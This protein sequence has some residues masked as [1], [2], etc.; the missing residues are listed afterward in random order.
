MKK[1]ILLLVSICCLAGNG[2]AEK[3][4]PSEMP[5]NTA[6]IPPDLL[7]NATAVMRD[8]EKVFWFKSAGKGELRL[9]YAVTVLNKNGLKHAV[10][11]QY[12]GGTTKIGKI[13]AT[14]YDH[15]GREI[16]KIRSEDFEDLS[17]AAGYTLYEDNRQKYYRPLGH[18]FP[19]TIEY[20]Y[21]LD[22]DGILNIPSWSPVAGF[23][24]STERSS[25]TVS[26]SGRT[27]V[28]Y[29]ELNLDQ[30]VEI[31]RSDDQ[32][33][34]TWEIRNIQA[35]E[36]EQYSPH[37]FTY[38]PRVILAPLEFEIEG[39]YGNMHSW[40]EFGVWAGKLMEG[41]DM[42]PEERVEEIKALV[43]GAQ[44]E[45][46]KVRRIYRYLQSRTRYI[47]I[48]EGIG[49]WQPFPAEAVDRL[50][51][52]DCKALANY[53][54]AL[55]AAAGIDAHY[56]KVR[57]GRNEID[58][59]PDFVS[60]QSN[61]IILCVPVKG[62]TIWL[63]CT[64][65][66]NPLGYIGNFTDDRYGLL[67]TDSGGTIVRTRRYKQ[68]ENY[69]YRNATVRL[70]PDGSGEAGIVTRYAGLQYDNVS[71]ILNESYERKEKQ[72]YNHLSLTNFEIK[73]FSYIS[74][75]EVVPVATETIS[76]KLNRYASVVG[77]RYF[78]TLNILNRLDYIPQEIENRKTQV[79]LR[80][81]FI[82]VDTISY[83]L[84]EGYRMESCPE[85]VFIENRYGSIDV[86]LIKEDN[87]L[88]YIRTRKMNSGYFPPDTYP[89]LVDLYRSISSADRMTLVLVHSD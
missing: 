83:T 89:E 60:N 15:S 72:L 48:Q 7:K 78:I 80:V 13:R 74:G 31:T 39:Y 79:W 26:V 6:K 85:E 36:S 64:S 77:K 10:F 84:P 19:F 16:K 38:L 29:R 61:H 9:R 63:E 27:R 24:I 55:L 3:G 73:D 5:Y 66:D 62:D 45:R 65:Q 69:Q 1:A 21:T 87:R 28:K 71:G 70:N 54:L 68:S 11:S 75:G 47:S 18:P 44:D 52:G 25:Y 81:P 23:Q 49:S 34:Y 35:M 32:T 59:M 8:Y 88:T 86:K 42:L 30:P 56:T 82:D 43:S 50:G 67:L 41:R 20:S 2:L 33:L 76:L 51:Y 53:A 22:Y 57:A 46:E 17:L 58:I 40:H 37:P 14:V 4:S 12:Y